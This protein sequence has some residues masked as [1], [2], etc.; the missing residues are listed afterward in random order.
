[1]IDTDLPSAP[2]AV[3]PTT[4]EPVS[5]DVVNDP[6]LPTEPD[7]VTAPA[8]DAEPAA[9]ADPVAEPPTAPTQGEP[10]APSDPKSVPNQ[11]FKRMKTAEESVK[12]YKEKFGDLPVDDGRGSNPSAPS[13]PVNT[14]DPIAIARAAKTLGEYDEVELDQLAIVATGL[15]VSPVEAAQSEGFKTFVLGHRTRIKKD[16]AV[17]APSGDAPTHLDK[18]AKEIGE[19][20]EEDFKQLEKDSQANQ[21]TTGI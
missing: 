17:P 12:A 6:S 8:P 9:P 7:D 3:A 20:S 14:S 18:T 2:D 11:I 15:G 1:M 21:N 10:E 19:M 13:T 16:N 5:T 4:P